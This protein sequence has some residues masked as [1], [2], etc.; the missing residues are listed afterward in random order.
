MRPS[1]SGTGPPARKSCPWPRSATSAATSAG[2]PSAP[3]VGF[4]PSPAVPRG[5]GCSM[6]PRSRP[7]GGRSS[8]CRPTPAGMP[9]IG[10]RPSA[11]SGAR[12]GSPPPGTW[13]SSSPGIPMTPISASAAMLHGHG[14]TT[15]RNKGQARRPRPNCLPTSSRGEGIAR[16]LDRK[17]T[18]RVAVTLAFRL[19]TLPRRQTGVFPGRADFLDTFLKDHHIVDNPVTASSAPESG[20]RGENQLVKWLDGEAPVLPNWHDRASILTSLDSRASSPLPQWGRRLPAGKDQSQRPVAASSARKGEANREAF[21]A[22]RST[23]GLSGRRDCS[24]RPAERPNHSG[25]T[26]DR[27][28]CEAGPA[29]AVWARARAGR[30]RVRRARSPG[31][32]V[33]VRGGE[34]PPV[35]GEG[36]DAKEFPAVFRPSRRIDESEKP[37]PTPWRGHVQVRID[38]GRGPPTALGFREKPRRACHTRG[39]LGIRRPIMTS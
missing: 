18:P 16:R 35:R 29:R 22:S 2:S 14:S 11:A 31:L 37:A 13:T 8:F 23:H 9:G 24:T 30:L 12:C 20:Q 25:T 26:H 27:S 19:L 6:P 4:S 33:G 32:D 28:H 39:L 17:C 15:K 5:S 21:E 36:H 1:G 7:C 10:T 3:T 34:R 38:S